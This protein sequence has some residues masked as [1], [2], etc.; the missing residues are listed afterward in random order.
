MF[1][2]GAT[3]DMNEV[4]TYGLPEAAAY[5]HLPY[6]LVSLWTQDGGLV[7]SSQKN[8]LSYANLL[9]LHVLNALRK[10]HRLPV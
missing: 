3:Q 4:P 9:E 5:L 8:L 1:Y 10:E 7:R 6:S 2:A